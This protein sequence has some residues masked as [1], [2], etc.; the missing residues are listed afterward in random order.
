MISLNR[1]GRRPPF[2]HAQRAL[3]IAVVVLATAPAITAATASAA[4]PSPTPVPAPVISRDFPDPSVLAVGSSYWAYSTASGY[5][6]AVRHVPLSRAIGLHGPWTDGGDAMPALPSWVDSVRGGSIWAPDVSAR[7]DGS[8][9]LY[10]TGRAKAPQ[11]VQCIGAALASSPKGPFHAVS[12]KPLV[13]RPDDVDSIDPS[14]FPDADGKQYVLYTS[15]R[16]KSTIWAQQVTK[17]GLTPVGERS[18]LL[19]ADRPEE[20]GVVEAPTL[21]RRGGKYVLFYSANRYNSGAYFANY[22]TA[23]SLAGP[24]VKSPGALLNKSSLG[25]GFTNPGGQDV[26]PGTKQDYLVFHG[27]ARP[28]QRSMYVVGLHWVGSK[29]T[30]R[31]DA[32]A[33]PAARAFTGNDQLPGGPAMPTERQGAAAQG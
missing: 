18:A 13:C 1:G 9:L 3:A 33:D 26:V 8:Y 27:Y 5:G 24:F 32:P 31:L 17:D 14:A 25:G 16:G 2:K 15:G 12:D 19:T 29:P 10:F 4:A 20:A 6:S 22:A 30:L 23:S 7:S 28:G 21:V 11:N